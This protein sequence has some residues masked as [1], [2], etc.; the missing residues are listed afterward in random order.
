MDKPSFVRAIETAL[1][2]RF[3][4]TKTRNGG[5]AW[6]NKDLALGHLI[7]YLVKKTYH[8]YTPKSSC[9]TLTRSEPTTGD[10]YIINIQ[11]NDKAGKVVITPAAPAFG[12]GAK[13]RL[14]AA[15]RLLASRRVTASVPDGFTNLDKLPRAKVL[16]VFKDVGKKFGAHF[17]AEQESLS[18]VV[19]PI[20]PEDIWKGHIVVEVLSEARLRRSG[21][22]ARGRLCVGYSSVTRAGILPPLESIDDFKKKLPILEAKL[23]VEPG[24]ID[25]A[26]AVKTLT[27]LVKALAALPAAKPLS[28]SVSDVV[29]MLSNIQEGVTE[30]QLKAGIEVSSAQMNTLFQLVTSH[31]YKGSK[32][33]GNTI[34]T[35]PDGDV[36]VIDTKNMTV[37][38]Q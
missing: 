18:S 6:T 14:N 20:D 9:N 24:T 29:D 19:F 11:G 25:H 4:A 30:E 1:S 38:L 36:L 10:W 28:A 34:S 22:Y 16:K 27:A 17:G 37:T 7:D 33:G 3:V 13:A 23:G 31:G 35:S 32:K 21:D 8:V 5:I 15:A 12:V 2:V 26:H